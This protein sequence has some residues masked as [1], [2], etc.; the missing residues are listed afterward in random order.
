MLWVG[1]DET[2]NHIISES[3]KLTQKECKIR[4]DCWG[5]IIHR[6]LCK[7]L[8]FDHAKKWYMHKPESCQRKWD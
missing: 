6:E 1:W 3:R 8:K 2:V 4:H 7:R 5:K